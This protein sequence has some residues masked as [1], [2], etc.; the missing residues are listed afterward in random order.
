[1]QLSRRD[2]LKA[3]A[4]FLTAA[5]FVDLHKAMAGYGAPSV[6]WIEGLGCSGC[7]VSFLNSIYYASVD[8]ILTKTI[9]LKFHNTIMAMAGDFAISPARLRSVSG[10]EVAAFSKE[11]MTTGS[12]LAFDLNK[13]RH[14]DMVDF[15]LLQQKGYILVVEGAIPFGAD[16]KYCDVG[17][18][19]NMVEA[20]NIFAQHASMVMAVGSCASFGGV[21]AGAPN[22]TEAKG[23]KDALVTLKIDKTVINIPG[24]PPHPDWIVGTIA[25]IIVMGNVPSLDSSGRP[26]KFFGPR[27]HD[28]CPNLQYYKDNYKKRADNHGEGVTVGT[29]SCLACHTNTDTHVKNPRQ[30]GMTGCLYA[31]NC[32]GRW[33]Y[34]DCP[35]RKWNS[36]GKGEFGVNWCVGADSPCHGC[37][38]SGFPD[39]FS[40]FF[41]PSGPGVDG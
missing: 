4:V 8:E 15:A 18:G 36:P 10:Q 24:C 27:I 11:W 14:V 12:D 17:G 32:K 29:R 28:Y 25:D 19:M 39:G 41:T 9:D 2:F 5:E 7:S 33:T 1:M 23:V 20:I 38:E 35:T 16:G 31:L 3:A 34:A 40:P 26:T 22:P 21:S 37:T 13:D 6:I 30:L